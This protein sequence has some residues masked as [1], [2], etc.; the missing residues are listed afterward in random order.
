MLTLLLPIIRIIIITY[1]SKLYWSISIAL[2][3]VLTLV[4]LPSIS[5]SVMYSISS[6]RLTDLIRSCIIVLSI[7][8][9]ALIVVASSKIFLSNNQPKIFITLNI[10]L[11]TILVLCFSARSILI[12][13]I[14]FEASLIPTI[15]IIM[16]WGYQ[17][18]RIQASIY[19][20]I[21][22]VTASLPILLSLLYVIHIRNHAILRI[23]F[24]WNYS[25]SA[26]INYLWLIILMG[27]LV[28]LPIFT[29]HLWLPKAHVEAP[30]AGSIVLAAILLKLGGYGLIRIVYIYNKINNVYISS[31]LIR[32]S[33]IG[34]IVTRLICLRQSDIKSLIAYS[35][36]GHIGLLLAAI[37]TNSNWAILGSLII[38]VAH[39]LCS[40]ALFILANLTYEISHT[41]RIYLTKGLLLACP[42][43]SMWWFLFAAWNIGAPPSINLIR[44]IILLTSILTASN[45]CIVLLILIRFLGAAYSLTIYTTT[46]HGALPSFIKPIINIKSKDMFLLTI[47]IV[48]IISLILK[49][50]VLST[51]S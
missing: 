1:I 30:I 37:I 5:V 35:S 21:Y 2:L 44:E 51:W 29:T 15:F 34:A 20:I 33:L 7:L 17:P 28:K 42:S 18:E 9:A 4:Y 8:V 27:F 16:L 39:G 48:P 14:W 19:L 38:I 40:S 47:H 36:V 13:Y 3:L 11:L 10:S 46:N 24:N 6:N 43:I 26:S 45:R 31:L 12:F 49:P 50:E 25:I 23:W 41:R 32:I 22:T